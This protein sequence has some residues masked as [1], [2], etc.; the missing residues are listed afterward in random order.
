MNKQVR[1]LR[2]GIASREAQKARMIAIAKGER[3]PTPDEP[4]VWFTSMESLA[5]VLSDRNRLLLELIAQSKPASISEL[6]AL[7]GRAKSNLV[8]TL[9]TMEAYRLVELHKGAH[10]RVEPRVAFDRLNLDVDLRNPR[11]RSLVALAS[12]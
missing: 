8:R 10:R 12:A 4:K 3:K 11:R 5:Q 9:R 7:S 6:A 2:I 1:T